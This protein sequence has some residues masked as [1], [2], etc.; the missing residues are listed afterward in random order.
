MRNRNHFRV[1]GASAMM[2][3]GLFFSNVSHAQESYWIKTDSLFK[4]I[5]PSASLQLWSVYSMHEQAQ[6]TTDGPLETV[7]DR[8]SFLARRARVGFKGKPYKKLSYNL[9]IQ[10]DNLGKDKL[11]S[12]RGGTNTGTLGILDAYITVRLTNNELVSITTG[13]FHPQISRECI[14]GDLLVN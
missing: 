2:L 12:L 1:F 14:T 9:S 5:Q 11:S 13:Y 7:E 4:Y 6:L 8:V 3:C 10:Y